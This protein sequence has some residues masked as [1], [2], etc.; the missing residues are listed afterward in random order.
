[1]YLRLAGVSLGEDASRLRAGKSWRFFAA[2]GNVV[3]SVLNRAGYANHAA[4]R[5]DLGWNRTGL[6][7]L[8]LLGL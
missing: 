2:A 4:A 6:Q 3:V 1:V 5:R 7:A 8:T